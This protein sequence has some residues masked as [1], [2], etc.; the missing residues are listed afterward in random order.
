MN[1]K[2]RGGGKKCV[3]LVC[4]SDGD[5]PVQALKLRRKKFDIN[6]ERHSGMVAITMPGSHC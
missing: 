1:I 5:M 2:A 4:L 6:K 3:S